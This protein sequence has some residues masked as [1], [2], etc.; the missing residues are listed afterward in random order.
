MY[1][2]E[3]PVG[4]AKDLRGQKFGR[5]TVL[6]R[7]H[8]PLAKKAYWKCQ[9]ECGNLFIAI[10]TELSSGHTKSCGCLKHETRKNLIGNK[11]GDLTVIDRA[12]NLQ[13]R[14]YW[15]CQCSC[16]NVINVRQDGLKN[17]TSCGCK[18]IR[19]DF[20]DVNIG[21]IFSRL[22]VISPSRRKANGKMECDCECECGNI[23][24]VEIRNLKYE[25]TRSCGCYQRDKVA[26]IGRLHKLDLTNQ[27]FGR[28]TAKYPT[29]KRISGCVVW[30]CECECGGVKDV[31]SV[32]LIKGATRSCGCL[33]SLGEENVRNLLEKNNRKYISHWHHDSCR[34]NDT[35]YLAEFDF[36]IID[37]DYIIEFDGIQH[38]KI[39]GWNTEERFKY[40]QEHDDFKNQ[41]CRENNIPLIRIPYWKLDTLCIEDLMLETTEFRVV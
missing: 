1:E 30:H 25:Q 5:L 24:S 36:Y 11:Y 20:Q 29:D 35:G 4:K 2:D 10:G 32:R 13:G 18:T 40:V 22:T 7:V 33:V 12:P 28:L 31:P 26:E 3:I 38:F 19:S 37:G 14:V 39:H 6:Y 27:K 34:F 9:C 41:W 23:I 15:K 16:G 17:K 8:G 21:D